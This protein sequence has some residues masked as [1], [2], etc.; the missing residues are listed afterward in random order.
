MQVTTTELEGHTAYNSRLSMPGI[1]KSAL[2]PGKLIVTAACNF[3]P[4]EIF[5]FIIFMFVALLRTAKQAHQ[6]RAEFIV[7][8]C[9][10]D[11]HP[12]FKTCSNFF[13]FDNE[14]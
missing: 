6:Q 12:N 4:V 9:F 13:L 14:K 8:F 1:L 10:L 5:I 11:V 2:R 3:G 7:N